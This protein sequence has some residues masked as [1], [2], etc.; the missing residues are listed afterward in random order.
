MD[1]LVDPIPGAAYNPDNG[2][3]STGVGSILPLST[4]SNG[5]L[6]LAVAMLAGGW[7]A[8]GNRTAPWFP[9]HGWAVRSEDFGKLF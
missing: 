3:W 1:L 9:A 8:D 7:D 6:L 2:F 4:P 5:C